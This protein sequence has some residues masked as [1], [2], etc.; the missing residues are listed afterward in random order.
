MAK[1]PTKGFTMDQLEKSS[2]RA[3]EQM[4]KSADILNKQNPESGGP[5]YESKD[6][7]Q[8]AGDDTYTYGKKD[9][10]PLNAYV[11]TAA[12]TSKMLS[13]LTAGAKQAVATVKEDE[14][15]EEG[16]EDKLSKWDIFM[17]MLEQ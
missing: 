10:S 12:S 17:K 4:K 7:Q 5:N 3:E 8:F 13:D 16:E 2:K 9:D 1:N 14:E 11:S 6:P 15:G